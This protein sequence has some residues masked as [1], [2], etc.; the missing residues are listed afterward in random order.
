V[1]FLAAIIFGCL[2]TV[3]VNPSEAPSMS[4]AGAA[5]GFA[6]AFGLCLVAAAIA[7]SGAK[8]PDTKREP[9]SDGTGSS[10]PPSS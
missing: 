3:R 9:K 6:V 2:T 5:C 7:E 8:K 4:T 10:P 1:C